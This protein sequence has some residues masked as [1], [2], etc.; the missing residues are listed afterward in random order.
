MP[1]GSGLVFI[2]NIATIRFTRKIFWIVDMKNFL[3]LILML[4][5]L[6]FGARA[7]FGIR[8]GF[9]TASTF[10]NGSRVQGSIP[11]W[12]LGFIT[13][14]NVGLGN[15]LKWHSGVEY[16]RVGHRQNDQN[17]RRVDYLAVPMGLKLQVVRRAF[18][19]GGISP[20]FKVGEEYRVGGN[21]AL[22]SSTR[23]SVFDL[24]MHIGAGFSIG[25]IDLEARYNTG[26]INVN[27]GNR[28][29]Y[30]QLGA[31]LRF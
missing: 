13:E 10:N 20:S 4:S 22:N 16:I 6:S 5:G 23:T 28:N 27:R 18:V 19:K 26:L 2:C 24:P 12:Y 3:I 31:A 1:N 8:A 14:D 25:L 11:G 17:F 15:F 29:R 30:L 9:Q 21:D 7:Q